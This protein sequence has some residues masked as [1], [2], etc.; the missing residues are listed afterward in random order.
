MSSEPLLRRDLISRLTSLHSTPVGSPRIAYNSSFYTPRA[1]PRGLAARALLV[2]SF[3]V[4]VVG[5]AMRASVCLASLLFLAVMTAVF[6]R[7]AAILGRVAVFDLLVVAAFRCRAFCSAVF[8]TGRLS[9]GRWLRPMSTSGR[10]RFPVP[11]SVDTLLRLP[12][13]R[14]LDRACFCFACLRA[15][16][17]SAFRAADL[18]AI[19]E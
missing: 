1:R 14:G 10:G 2:S 4:S 3:C 19:L 16:C 11:G 8:E 18:S 5:A 12:T 9:S 13:L 17:S 7:L 15:G 6:L